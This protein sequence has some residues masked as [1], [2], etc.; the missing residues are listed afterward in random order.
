V[1]NQKPVATNKM[2]M[3]QFG[4][5]KKLFPLCLVSYAKPTQADI[6]QYE[7][8]MKAARLHDDM[9]GKREAFFPTPTTAFFSTNHSKRLITETSTFHIMDRPTFHC[10]FCILPTFLLDSAVLTFDQH[11]YQ[12]RNANIHQQHQRQQPIVCCD[13]QQNFYFHT[14]LLMQ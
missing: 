13:E 3:L 12:Q 8:A 10:H 6:T 9:V 4:A 11:Y 5:N 14:S 7:T 2:L 1:K